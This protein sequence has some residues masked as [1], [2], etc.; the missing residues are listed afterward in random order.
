V[1]SR[2]RTTCSRLGLKCHVPLSGSLTGGI[3]PSIAADSA[4]SA[5]RLVGQ[6][7]LWSRFINRLLFWRISAQFLQPYDAYRP[8]RCEAAGTLCPDPSFAWRE[9]PSEPSPGLFPLAH[10]VLTR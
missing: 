2:R 3:T 10:Q 1:V 7:D 6:R 9:A 4:Y 8:H 5:M